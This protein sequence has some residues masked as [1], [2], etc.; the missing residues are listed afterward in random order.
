MVRV[1]LQGR[2]GQLTGERTS[3][4]YHSHLSERIARKTLYASELSLRYLCVLF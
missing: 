4:I 2:N 1:C 3:A